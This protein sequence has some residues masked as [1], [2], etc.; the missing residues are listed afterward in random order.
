MDTEVKKHIK[1]FA[2][3]CS[4]AM[5][6]GLFSVGTF[7]K[8]AGTTNLDQQYI[9]DHSGKL[10]V[11]SGNYVLTQDI[12]VGDTTQIDVDGADITIDLAGHKIT[13][14][15]S[16][17]MY[18]VGLVDTEH[19]TVV[20]SNVHLT[21]N[22]S[23]GGGLITTSDDYTG[24][25]SVDHWISGDFGTEKLM[26]GGC[27]LIQYGSYF[28]LNGGTING[29]YAQDEGGAVL[30][31]NGSHFV[32]NGGKITNC[33]AGNAGGAISVNASSKG[34][35]KTINGTTYYVAGSAKIF[36]GEISGNSAKNLGGG[37]RVTRADLYLK[38]CVITGNTVE[39]GA[40][41]NG[42]GGIQILNYSGQIL[43]M[44]GN[45]TINGNHCTADAKKANLYFNN[46]T[47]INLTGALDPDARIAFGEQSASTSCQFFKINGNTYSEDNFIC[48]NSGYYPYY[49]SE[50]DAI[51]INNSAKPKILGYTVTVGGRIELNA[52]VNLGTFDNGNTTVDYSYSYTKNGNT[53]NVNKSIAKSALEADG[54]NYIAHIPVESACMTAP[55]TITVKYGTSGE[56]VG[57]TVTINDY[58]NTI[59]SDTTGKYT[60]AE[61]EAAKAL[62]IYGGYAQ[63]Q[64][65]IN[66]GDLP[67]GT[68]ANFDGNFDGGLVGAAYTPG[69]DAFY[70]GNVS[71][72][73]QTEVKLAFKKSVLG[74]E[75]PTMTVSYGS[76]STETISAT[77]NG[78]YY[79]YTVKGPN[80]NGFSATQFA[81][82]F[83]YS[84]GNVSGTYSVETYL[85]AVKASGTT[86]TA[87][88]NL[89]EA[90]NN[91]AQKCKALA[92]N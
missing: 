47:S 49:N 17:S 81:N 18:I 1:A 6:F 58:A 60:S 4:M 7:A 79:V 71:F 46:N 13:Y 72:L 34:R 32:M 5:V 20:A 78:G 53:T 77:P 66:T 62:L 70:A 38:N 39:N 43:E 92:Q 64:L 33:R 82:T 63:K 37:V 55:I 86:S 45:V 31:S 41:V 3:V 85:K 29:F 11:E 40:G 25:G 2:A 22:D 74:D 57:N 61:K 89:A 26:R 76:S 12:T 75:A 90:Y 10:P 21:I 8:E 9:T 24:G 91:F 56:V 23:Q 28:T 80:G 48:D 52:T 19:K 51:M 42:G 54:N 67:T 36:G 27:V 50:N 44:E 73:S 14:S 30:I 88:K 35:V 59:M 65:K 84:V 16:G 83:D 68:G 87:M 15:G 69:N